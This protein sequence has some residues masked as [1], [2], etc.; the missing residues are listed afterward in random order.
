[1]ALNQGLAISGLL[2]VF[3]LAA[4]RGLIQIR[5]AIEALRR[6]TF[7]IDPRLLKLVLDK[8]T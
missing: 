6:T 4:E 5:E 7:R 3:G 8:H 1:M 2:G